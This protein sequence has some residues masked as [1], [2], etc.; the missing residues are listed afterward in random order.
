MH[1]AIPAFDL[2]DKTHEFIWNTLA[3]RLSDKDFEAIQLSLLDRADMIDDIKK[4]E[5]SYRDFG[6]DGLYQPRPVSV[7]EREGA[8]KYTNWACAVDILLVLSK[9]CDLRPK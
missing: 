1:E 5:I 3:M 2:G 9:Y 4:S 7:A 6:K 8:L